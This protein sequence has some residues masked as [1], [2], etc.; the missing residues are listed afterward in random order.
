MAR[1]ELIV[2]EL[3]VKYSI[4]KSEL[5]GQEWKR[6]KDLKLTSEM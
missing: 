6:A 1:M 2:G 5:Y 4:C 3:K